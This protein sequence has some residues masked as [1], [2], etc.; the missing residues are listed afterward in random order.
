MSLWATESVHY[1]GIRVNVLTWDGLRRAGVDLRSMLGK[2]L[3]IKVFFPDAFFFLP[4]DVFHLTLKDLSVEGVSPLVVEP[5]P[6]RL[7]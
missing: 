6:Q 3:H 4:C 7:D 1:Y 5:A 2:N